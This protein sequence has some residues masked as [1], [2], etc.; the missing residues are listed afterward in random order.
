MI[1][2][3]RD[4]ELRQD[5][6]G[7]FENF[8]ISE[9]EKSRKLANAKVNI[10]FYREY[11]GKEIDLVVEDYKKN[12]TA[13][14]IKLDKGAMKNIFPLPATSEIINMQNYFEKISKILA[15]K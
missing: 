12:Y 4:L 15:G 2:D 11:G 14:E 13:A 3:F 9:L 10:Y 8:I 7:V 1:Q 6:G 5:K